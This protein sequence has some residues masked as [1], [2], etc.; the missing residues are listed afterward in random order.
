MPGIEL[1]SVRGSTRLWREQVH[2]GFT[3][4]AIAA[5][6]PALEAT[7]R[8]R[9][10]TVS[11]INGQLMLINAGDGHVTQRVSRPARFD[12]VKLS[13][14]LI[15]EAVQSSRRSGGFYF[16]HPSCAEPSVL[17]A[18]ERLARYVAAGE[19]ELVIEE[20][21][22]ELAQLVVTRLGEPGKGELDPVRDYRLRRVRDHIHVSAR[23]ESPKPRLSTLAAEV[24][25]C[26]F[27]LCALFKRMYGLSI[28]AYWT[29][30]RMSE[31]KRLLLSGVMLR[32]I[33]A[34]LHFSDEPQFVRFFRRE[35]GLSP[36][37]WRDLYLAS[38]AQRGRPAPASQ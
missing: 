18:I 6:Q 17:S 28:G 8:T 10:R 23:G 15:Q 35:H 3:V 29:S 20:C 38:R 21:G 33:A 2:E 19:D 24:D 27:R 30:C 7:W 16:R 12:V 14:C 1:M 13:P 36:G 31:A 5:H 26:E 37:R 25:L 4:A 22:A 11:T 32:N 34:R 9:C